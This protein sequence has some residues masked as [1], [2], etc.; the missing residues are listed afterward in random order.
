MYQKHSIAFHCRSSGSCSLLSLWAYCL[1]RRPIIHLRCAVSSSKISS[2]AKK[3]TTWLTVNMLPPGMWARAAPCLSYHRCTHPKKYF[4]FSSDKIIRDSSMYVSAV[5]MVAGAFEIWF[6]TII[7]RCYRFFLDKDA[8]GR[9][10]LTR[11]NEYMIWSSARPLDAHPLLQYSTVSC[12]IEIFILRIA[13]PVNT[14]RF[15]TEFFYLLWFWISL[16]GMV[17]ILI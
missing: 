3:L 6:F 17:K 8:Y 7:L 15:E 5:V 4:F 2:T 1:L 9:C 11:R 14:F 16:D 10:W 12:N 13:F